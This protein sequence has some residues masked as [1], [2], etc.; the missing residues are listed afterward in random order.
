[1]SRNRMAL[2]IAA[3]AFLGWMIFLGS[4]AWQYRNPPVIVSRAQLLAS[5][6]DVVADVA[7]DPTDPAKPALNVTV[8][9]VL[10]SADANAAPKKG[11]TITVQNL[12]SGIGF[13][14][15][16][17][18]VLPL[19]KR[20][21]LYYLAVPPVDPGVPK[22]FDP[23]LYPATEEVRRQFADIRAGKG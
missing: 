3:A 22:T 12:A 6:Y 2:I 9:E 8:Q 10:Y 15:A 17:A 20:N 21:G 1:M 23:R 18:Y 4:K 7:A 19:S 13:H 11:Q 14:G 5:E 16:G